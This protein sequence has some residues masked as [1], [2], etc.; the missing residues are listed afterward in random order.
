[1]HDFDNA[2]KEILNF[3]DRAIIHFL[4]ANFDA[5]HPPDARLIRAGTEHR[6]PALPAGEPLQS[7]TIIADETFLVEGSV[8][9]HIEA[10]LTRR[11]GMALRMF[12]YDIAQ[13]LAQ[14]V[15]EDGVETIRLPK[16][17]VIYLEPPPGAPDHELLRVIFPDGSV[18]E[19]RTPAIK[20]PD[21]S[22]EELLERHLVIFAP[23][24]I[25]KLRRQTKRAKTR[26][27]RRALAAELRRLYQEL[28][29]AMQ[30]EQEAGIMAEADGEKV[31]E[32]TEVLR[33]KL[34]GSYT[35]FKEDE[36]GKPIEF[37]NLRVIEQL[38]VEIDEIKRAREEALSRA[39]LDRQR[40]RDTALNILRAGQPV[41]QVAQWTGL[42]PETVQTLAA[43]LSK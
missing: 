35:E 20:L 41:E 32:M 9:Y 22:V 4:N 34:Y 18:H 37:P 39:E 42:P 25:L 40:L 38:H 33:D 1:M 6:L 11:S 17:L 7:K 15:E 26:E 19:H 10:Q 14:P 21:L 24:Y 2:A 36:M 29:K 31:V 13:A 23:L 43:Q 3:S 12:R 30:Q 28:G 16:S 5:S 27:E 8:Y